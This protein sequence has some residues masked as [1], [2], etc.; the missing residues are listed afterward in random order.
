MNTHSNKNHD[1][2]EISGFYN[3]I[4]REEK[5]TSDGEYFEVFTLYAYDK[6][7]T[8][9]IFD[10]HF[11]EGECLRKNAIV[12][13]RGQLHHNKSIFNAELKPTIIAPVYNILDV[14]IRTLP[15]S[16]G[17]SWPD[18]KAVDEMVEMLES[19]QFEALR[20]AVTQ[21]FM[22]GDLIERFIH[23][24][25]SQK[26]HHSKPGGLIRHSVDVAK[27]VRVMIEENDKTMPVEL[28]ETA[29]VAALLH[30]IG[31]T[32]TYSSTGFNEQKSRLI[33]HDALTLELSS[34][35]LKYLDQLCP[36]IADTLRHIW[37]ANSYGS[38]YGIKTKT[39]LFD[40]VKSADRLNSASYIQ[41]SYSSDY[42]YQGF[43]KLL[44]GSILWFPL[45]RN[46]SS[47]R[48]DLVSME[49]GHD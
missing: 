46:V 19:F 39:I 31:K 44:N 15:R 32:Q 37:T 1:S 18:S 13:V 41:T 12:Y 2:Y 7:F 10:N 36:A 30:D 29:M 6:E 45:S 40:Y 26:S 38:K 33:S 48:A 21:I 49:V 8:V 23:F 47:E 24:P 27:L 17:F 42:Q 35:G 43:K 3:V 28:K 16:Y 9:S 5:F 25:G 14:P 11:V 20:V 4:A 34:P 22:Q